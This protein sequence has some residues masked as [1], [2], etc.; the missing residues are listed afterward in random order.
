MDNDK[1]IIDQIVERIVNTAH[2]DKIILFGSRAR[3]D[4]N[5]LSDYDLLVVM[6]FTGKRRDI[7]VEIDMAL[8][9]LG[10]ARDV[11]ILSPQEYEETQKI[12]GTISQPAAE[13]GIVLYERK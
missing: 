8:A 5:E 12:P 6:S 11:I 2:P 3:G 9:G 7:M 4:T 10:I 1:N 13:E